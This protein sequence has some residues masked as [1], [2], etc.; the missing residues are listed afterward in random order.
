MKR[1]FALPA[2]IA[3]TA[4]ALL[5]MGSGKPPMPI[6]PVPTSIPPLEDK[7]K[8][9]LVDNTPPVIDDIGDEVVSTNT[10][11]PP[12][13]PELPPTDIPMG[14]VI[15]Q[16][17]V[18]TTHGN[19]TKISPGLNV[20]RPGGDGNKPISPSLLDKPPRTRSQK[21][22]VYPY[23]MKVAGTAGTVWVDFIVDETGCV[24]D[25]RVLK[26][27]HSDFEEATIAAVSLWR[28]EPGKHNNKPVCFRMSI[29]V[30]F[31]VAD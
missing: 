3:L 9:L 29:P 30:V 6:S 23:A 18:P 11:Y 22:P 14:P 28:F 26:S 4:H 17:Y 12:G 27:T 15:T 1:R 24:H 31:K 8:I 7:D 10:E 2:A 25:V 21:E 13:I 16:T 19:T 5:F 20:G